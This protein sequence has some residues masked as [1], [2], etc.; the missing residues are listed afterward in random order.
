MVVFV[1]VFFS[2]LFPLAKLYDQNFHHPAL[3]Q[4][5]TDWPV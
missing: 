5:V 3:D 4:Q 2:L 1:F